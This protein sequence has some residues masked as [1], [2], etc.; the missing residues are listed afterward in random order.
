MGYLLSIFTLLLVSGR[1]SFLIDLILPFDIPDRVL[2]KLVWVL[3]YIAGLSVALV[4]CQRKYGGFVSFSRVLWVKY[5]ELLIYYFLF[6]IGGT[7]S[8]FFAYSSQ[9][10]I[11]GLL[12][13]MAI[14]SLIFFGVLVFRSRYVRQFKDGLY[15]GTLILIGI[16]LAQYFDYRYNQNLGWFVSLFD[17][18]GFVPVSAFNFRTADIGLFLRPSS[19]LT[20]A[21]VFGVF[22]ATIIMFLFDDFKRRGVTLLAISTMIL[23][24]L[25]LFMTA[26]RTGFIAIGF[27]ILIYSLI[28]LYRSRARLFAITPF[29]LFIERF[30]LKDSSA[31]EHIN[32]WV[33]SVKIF[34]SH[35]FTG[36]GYGGFPLYYRE[37]IDSQMEFATPHSTFAKVISE[38]GVLG[39]IPLLMLL[40]SIFVRLVSSRNAITISVFLMLVFANLT[41]DILLLPWVWFLFGAFI[42][43]TK[44]D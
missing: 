31:L 20:D 3:V 40:V 25:M 23:S 42:S 17:N 26:S 18:G 9:L 1:L 36:V 33:Q 4:Y 22:L 38:G 30:S 28:S 27:G 43:D 6:A 21:N 41:Y 44:W 8:F 15:I 13:Y 16:G 14:L 29:S 11:I 24:V 37:K 34:I 5:R 12:Y 19:L 10:H 2:S 35:P 39:L 7:I 32:Y